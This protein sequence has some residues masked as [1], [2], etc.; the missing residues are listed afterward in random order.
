MT[1]AYACPVLLF[2]PDVEAWLQLFTVTHALRVGL[3]GARWERIALPVSGGIDEQ[4]AKDLHALSW[5][6][7]VWNAWL[8]EQR[9][10]RRRPTPE[11]RG[12]R[13]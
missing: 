7:D 6:A 9:S 10:P 12:R 3:G 5:I 11:S 2:T 13:G 8:A 1:V 4:P